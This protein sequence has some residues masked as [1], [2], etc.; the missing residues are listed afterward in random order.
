MSIAELLHHV[1]VRHV[2]VSENGNAKGSS[3]PVWANGLAMHSFNPSIRS[4]QYA[5]DLG[6]LYHV[7]QKN[8]H[9]QYELPTKGGRSAITG[10]TGFPQVDVGA[11]RH[12]CCD[13]AATVGSRS[14][15]Q[16]SR[17]QGNPPLTDGLLTP[18]ME[19][20]RTGSVSK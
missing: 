7:D 20:S 1:F 11:G 14:L 15:A 13:V 19:V 9:P 12:D 3:C 4:L 16:T 10:L 17:S 6:S 2:W 5:C 8:L 18:V